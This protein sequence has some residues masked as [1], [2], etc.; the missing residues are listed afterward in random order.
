M[1]TMNLASLGLGRRRKSKLVV[2]LLAIV[3]CIV[4]PSQGVAQHY[5]EEKGTPWVVINARDTLEWQLSD[6]FLNPLASLST[7]VGNQL[8]FAYVNGGYQGVTKGGVSVKIGSVGYEFTWAA[9]MTANFPLKKRFGLKASKTFLSTSEVVVE[10]TDDVPY[11]SFPSSG[12]YELARSGGDFLMPPESGS[13]IDELLKIE[14]DVSLIGR[15]M[16]LP[17]IQVLCGDVSGD[18]AQSMWPELSEY[19]GNTVS[20]WWLSWDF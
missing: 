17:M 15:L 18:E 3:A 8:K 9:V 1:R 4:M 10:A 14:G 13:A 2:V 19:L 5:F 7:L 16:S 20:F 11:L 12:L 6:V